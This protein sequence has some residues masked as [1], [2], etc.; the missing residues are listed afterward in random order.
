MI[1]PRVLR[2]AETNQGVSLL[3]EVVPGALLGVSM[4]TAMPK[5]L[6]DEV[7]KLPTLLQRNRSAFQTHIRSSG[8]LL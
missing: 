5:I 3:K 7:P 2:D 1:A 6:E 8:E 4:R